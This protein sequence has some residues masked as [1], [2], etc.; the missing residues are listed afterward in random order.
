MIP[1]FPPVGCRHY[2]FISWSTQEEVLTH[3]TQYLRTTNISGKILIQ[4][5]LEWYEED[6]RNEDA[7]KK[8]EYNMGLMGSDVK[9]AGIGPYKGTGIAKQR[10]IKDFNMIFLPNMFRQD[11]NHQDSGVLITKNEWVYWEMEGSKTSL[12]NYYRFCL[13]RLLYCRHLVN[14]VY[15]FYELREAL[16][17]IQALK[18]LQI[19]HYGY[20]KVPG[21]N[22]TTYNDTWTVFTSFPVRNV[23]DKSKIIDSI[24]T[25]PGNTLQALTTIGDVSGETDIKALLN[26]KEYKK[27]YDKLSKG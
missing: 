15:L 12:F 5:P 6:L 22:Y 4:V 14:I 16:P 10:S 25:S 26:N 8:W 9:F 27:V 13:V 17:K 11:N 19:A 3:C 7:F 23:V 21:P 24:K 18:L 2:S 20:S 1:N